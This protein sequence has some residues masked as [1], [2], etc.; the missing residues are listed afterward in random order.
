MIAVSVL[1]ASGVRKLY[2][3]E[4][5]VGDEV[6]PLPEGGLGEA[7]PSPPKVFQ[8]GTIIDSTIMDHQSNATIHQRIAAIGDSALHVTA[9][10]STDEGILERG[11]RY[12]YYN[13]QVF[14]NAGYIEGNG[15]GD[16]RGGYG[17]VVGYY[18]PERGIGN[19][20]V[21]TSHVNLSSMAY[22]SHWYSF[23]DLFQGLGAFGSFEGPPGDGSD[24][25][26]RLLWPSL[27]VVNDLTGEM[28]MTAFT[29]DASCAGGID[30]IKVTHKTFDDAQWGEPVLL[31]TLDDATAWGNGPEIPMLAGADNGYMAIAS[32]DFTTNVYMW[33]STDSGVSWGDRISITNLPIEPYQ[34]PPDS[35][36]TVYVP[37]QNAAIAVSRNGTPH[38]VW[39]S[40][41]ARG[42]ETDSIFTPGSGAW[43]YRTKLEHWDPVN[44]ITEIYRHPS[45]LADQA[46]GTAFAYNVGHPTIGFGPSDDIIYVVYEGFVDADMDPTNNLFFGDIYVSHSTDGGATWSDRVNITNT[47]GSDD[48]YPAIARL[49][50]Q[51]VV[52][53]L[54]GFSVGSFDGIN[55]F[56]MVYQ[57]DDVAGT[58]LRGEEPEANWDMLLVAPVDFEAI[59]GTGIG[60][61]EGEGAG[62]PKGVTLTQNFPNPF[63]PQTTIRYSLAEDASVRLSIHNLRGEVVRILVDGSQS[64]GEHTVGWDGRNEMGETVSSGIYFYSLKLGDGSSVTKK[65]VLLK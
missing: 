59:P 26:D 16:Q 51:G 25:C 19:V 65:M 33:E 11:M 44:G 21:M 5:L 18:A 39:T 23:Q 40:Y 63:N 45:G 10:I 56:V 7:I 57:N 14:Q 13:G 27:Y 1:S 4:P 22:G 64:S 55:D 48:L 36:S 12:Y 35:T 49:N 29:F 38:V 34:V 47:V 28:A 24:V 17:S 37:M 32:A 62:V 3:E 50:P 54:E 2:R 30:D 42:G 6:L 8:V 53:E 43:Q 61:D 31:H 9:M 58:F 15:L 20:A 60:G 41:Q 52:Q 46:G